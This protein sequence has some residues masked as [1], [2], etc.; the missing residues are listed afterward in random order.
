VL[1]IFEAL[2]KRS[3]AVGM[4]IGSTALGMIVPGIMAKEGW[5]DHDRSL[6]SLSRDCAIDY[7]QSCAPNAILF[8]NGD[9]DTFPLW[10]AQEVEG[11]RTD[12]RVINLSLLNT[13]WYI[14]QMRRAAYESA[15]VP[16][17]IAEDKL[18]AEKLSYMV[19]NT[20]N[21]APMSVKD[22]IT[23]GIEDVRSK[24]DN[25]GGD[26]IDVLPTKSLYVEVDSLAVMQN[27]VISVSDTGRLAKRISW[28][29]TN[30]SY[31]MKNDL[32]VLD[33]IANNNWK[34]PIYF[35]VT[36]GDEAYVGLKRYFQ[37]EGLAYRFVPIKQTESEEAQGGRVNTEVMYDNIMNKFLWG[38]MD[39]KG[40]NLDENCVRMTGNL[41]MQMGILAGALISEGKN[42]K[43]EAVLD[44]CL[45]VMPDENIPFDATIFT[46]C[47]N[48]Y[49]LKQF[50]KANELSKKLFDIFE[51]DLKIYNAQKGN[52][53]YAYSRDMNQCKEILKRLVGLAQQFRQEELY[54]GYMNRVKNVMSAEDFNPPS[55]EAQPQLP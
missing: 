19:I 27:K 40:V 46:I 41:R 28:E 54:S 43:A 12:V 48:Y 34:R 50:K 39:K 23:T 55:Q 10:Y 35:A 53:R 45:Q 15:A 14:K 9:N 16:F 52:H 33:L 18:E 49:E 25:G 47:A 44:K 24:I 30:R 37:L 36:T 13:D 1:S 5:N 20:Q 21:P 7:L 51:G 38:G 29:L 17:T 2:S 32:M 3:A 42:K 11:I 4:A 8:T 31:I 22:A 6:R 26:L